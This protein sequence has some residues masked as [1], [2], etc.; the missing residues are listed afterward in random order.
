M[1]DNEQT[2]TTTPK[3]FLSLLWTAVKYIVVAAWIILILAKIAL[4]TGLLQGR[5]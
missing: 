3:R 4:K 5:E 2:S 1:A